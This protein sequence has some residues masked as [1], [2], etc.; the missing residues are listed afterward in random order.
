MDLETYE[1]GIIVGV[2]GSFAIGVLATWAIA[3]FGTEKFKKRF[4]SHIWKETKKEKLRRAYEINFYDNPFMQTGSHSAYFQY[5]A[6]TYKCVVCGKEY[7]T[8]SREKDD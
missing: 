2:L 1:V 7:I 4:H 6:I 3:I 5:Y 8:E